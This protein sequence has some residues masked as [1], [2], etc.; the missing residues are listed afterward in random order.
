[1]SI[2]P[3]T[4]L[5]TGDV[6]AGTVA[7]VEIGNDEFVV[8]RGYSGALCVMARQ[9]PHL[10]W[11]LTEATVL[12]DE[13]VCP[14]HGWSFGCDGRAFKRNLTG[15]EDPKDHVETLPV[16]EVDGEIRIVRAAS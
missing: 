11:D 1:V 2:G 3:E 12:D 16:E 6:P 7:P 10:D 8:W 15:R 5:R 14:G 13:L 4:I 9:C